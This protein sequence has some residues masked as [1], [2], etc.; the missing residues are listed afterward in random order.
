MK[1][2]KTPAFSLAVNNFDCRLLEDYEACPEIKITI[3][4]SPKSAKSTKTLSILCT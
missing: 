3:F 2:M 4:P 1:K